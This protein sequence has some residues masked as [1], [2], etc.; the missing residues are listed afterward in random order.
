MVDQGRPE[1]A[2]EAGEGPDGEEHGGC[3]E[4]RSAG[5]DRKRELR[6]ERT[7]RSGCTRAGLGQQDDAERPHDQHTGEGD[8][9]QLRSS[10]KP[11]HGE[12]GQ[13]R[14]A[15][16]SQTGCGGVGHSTA[17]LVDVEHGADGGDRPARRQALNDARGDECGDAVRVDED[18]PRRRS[19]RRLRGRAA[20]R[21]SETWRLS[22]LLVVVVALGAGGAGGAVAGVRESHS[23]GGGSHGS[24]AGSV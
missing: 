17:R 16:R 2:V 6:Y 11:P 3:S 7:P 18:C 15:R 9:D 14:T 19:V 13:E 1:R 5:L 24:R 21:S 23:T 4:Q 8:A 12:R 22:S 20:I 10:R